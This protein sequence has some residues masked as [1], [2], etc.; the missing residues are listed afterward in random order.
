MQPDIFTKLKIKT[1]LTIKLQKAKTGLN[2]KKL[3]LK[4]NSIAKPKNG[5]GTSAKLSTKLEN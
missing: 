3:E 4:S 5:P 2:K 1:C